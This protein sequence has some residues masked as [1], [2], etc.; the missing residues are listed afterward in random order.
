MLLR[1]ARHPASVLLVKYDILS[2]KVKVTKRLT[3]NDEFLRLISY[4]LNAFS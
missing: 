4:F 2:V 3:N 1:R